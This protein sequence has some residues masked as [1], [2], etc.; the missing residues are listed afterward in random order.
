V[1]GLRDEG[2]APL[3]DLRVVDF[4]Q[5]V[6]GPLAAGLLAEQGAEVVHVDPPGGPRWDRPAN[7]ALLRSRRSLVLDL[8]DADDLTEARSLV[9]TADVVVENFRPGVMDR[10]GLGPT[11]SLAANPRLVYCS[12]PGLGATDKRAG[13]PG[14]GRDGGGRRLS[15]RR[16]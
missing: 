8:R 16:R 10:L 9:A 3:G 4:G 11:A 2:P 14:R 5:Y 13:L 15:G 12:L 7:A 6:A 1:T